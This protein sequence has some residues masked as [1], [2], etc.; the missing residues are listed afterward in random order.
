MLPNYLLTHKQTSEETKWNIHMHP[1]S[2]EILLFKKG[3]VDFY[4]NSQFTHLCPGDL[5]LIP[6][7]LVHGYCAKDCSTYERITTHISEDF[8]DTLCTEQNNLLK[9]FSQNEPRFLHMETQQISLYEMYVDSAI[10]Y[11]KENQFG[12]DIFIKSTLSLLLLLINTTD[13]NI[14][15]NT[16]KDAFPELI[17][18]TLTYIDK[19]YTEEI[20]VQTIAY[21]LG[22]SSSRLCHVFKDFM[23]VSLWNYVITKRIQLAKL[24]L[25]EGSSITNAC[26]ECGFQDYSH[27]L[28]SFHN[29]VGVTPKKYIQGIS[30]HQS[31][32][33]PPTHT[34]SA[35]KSILCVPQCHSCSAVS[36]AITWTNSIKNLQKQL[37]I[38]HNMEIQSCLVCFI[39]RLNLS[40]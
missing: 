31:F 15:A 40:F 37:C 7:N 38:S 10:A 23:G 9:C 11:L 28:R 34:I 20:S 16:A 22:I 26:Y 6:P 30:M 17:F 25:D 33:P 24:L 36:S 4:I 27:F 3:N 5:I 29:L 21:H 2:L 39:M 13:Q 12:Q 32:P 35:L 8:A 14:S 1:N 18:R 19:H